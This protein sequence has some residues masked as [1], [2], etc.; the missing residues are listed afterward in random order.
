MS[1]I[2]ETNNQMNPEGSESDRYLTY[3]AGEEKEF[4]AA[5]L[6]FSGLLAQEGCEDQLLSELFVLLKTTT[7]L[8]GVARV[9]RFIQLSDLF[10]SLIVD[11]DLYMLEQVKDKVCYLPIEEAIELAMIGKIYR[12]NI[13]FFPERADD[14]RVEWIHKLK[15]K[16]RSVKAIDIANSIENRARRA[17]ARQWV[18]GP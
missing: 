10:S 7:I 18:L 4:R 9:E 14:F 13:A 11:V 3:D 15:E 12:R 16:N 8:K 5:T 6:L 17:A 2:T 1:A